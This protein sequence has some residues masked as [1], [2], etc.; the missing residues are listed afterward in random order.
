[1]TI[2]KFPGIGDTR[3]AFESAMARRLRVTVAFWEIKRDDGG[4]VIK[5][6]DGG[7]QWEYALRTLEFFDQRETIDGNFVF[8]GMAHHSPRDG[9]GPCVRSVRLD[10]V[11]EWTEHKRCHY[12]IPNTYFIK[13]VRDH[14]AERHTPDRLK[15]LWDVVTDVWTDADIWEVI[16]GAATPEESIARMAQYA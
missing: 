2:R 5:G 4:R 10:R 14:A 6:A 13:K 15:T 3:V 12:I 7:E 1:M 8:I 16:Q 9:W 11:I